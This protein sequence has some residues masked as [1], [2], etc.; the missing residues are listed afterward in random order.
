MYGTQTS[1]WKT[2]RYGTLSIALRR[3][4]GEL[5][6]SYVPRPGHSTVSALSLRVNATRALCL[7]IKLKGRTPV[8]AAVTAWRLSKLTLEMRD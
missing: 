2:D 3:C 4:F 8:I 7:M 5:R 6:T 1:F